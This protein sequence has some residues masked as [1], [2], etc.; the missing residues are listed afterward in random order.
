MFTTCTA[1]SSGADVFALCPL[2]TRLSG[3]LKSEVAGVPSAPDPLG[4]GQDPEWTTEMVTAVPSAT[5]GVAHVTLGTGPG[6]TTEKL[7]L[8]VVLQGS[9]LL[10]DDLYCTGADPTTGDVFAPG[11]LARSVCTS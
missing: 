11:W 7:D 9:Q 4:G 8:I 1:G 6:A 5:G 3:Q 10:V 2:T